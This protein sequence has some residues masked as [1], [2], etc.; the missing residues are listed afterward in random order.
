M[1]QNVG[2]DETGRAVEMGETEIS[3][4]HANFAVKKISDPGTH[5]RA[6]ML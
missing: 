1:S 2:V 3:K 6:M 4:S 5:R